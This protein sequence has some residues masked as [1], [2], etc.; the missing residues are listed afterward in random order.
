MSETGAGPPRGRILQ[1][2]A[3][4]ERIVLLRT[5]EETAGELLEFELRLAAG[6]HVPSAHLHPEQEERF[7][8]LEGHTRFR[9]GRRT[10]VLTAGQTVTVPPGTAHRF[11]NPG[12]GNARLLVQVRPALHMQELLET[13]SALS[14]QGSRLLPGQ[15]HLVD[16]A[17][18]LDEFEREVRA[19]VLPRLTVRAM[20]RPLA[21]LARA[22]GL[23]A[24]YRRLRRS[25][26]LDGE[27][28]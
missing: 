24:R 3:S 6:G 23:D 14:L 10:V 26:P 2:P 8:V 11:D 9:V 16:L 15:P 13:A 20:A 21:W 7:T 12:P 19:P 17:L 18:F 25:E 5:S 1:N 22:T 27:R 28:S 4:G